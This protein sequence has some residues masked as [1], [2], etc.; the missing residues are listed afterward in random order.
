MTVAPLERSS[1]LR[2]C[3][4]A[5]VSITSPRG[6][7]FTFAKRTITSQIRHSICSDLKIIFGQKRVTHFALFWL[8]SIMKSRDNAANSGRAW[9][10]TAHRVR[11][12]AWAC[13]LLHVAFKFLQAICNLNGRFWCYTNAWNVKHLF[14][15]IHNQKLTATIA[16]EC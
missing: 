8:V 7:T 3:L 5:K 15:I 1:C 2:T 6:R 16:A 12:A 4:P 14:C 13:S 10:G 11:D 9:R